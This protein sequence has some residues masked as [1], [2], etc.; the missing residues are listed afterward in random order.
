MLCCKGIRFANLVSRRL[1]L[2]N[3]KHATMPLVKMSRNKKH[4]LA[5]AHA[6]AHTHA[7][8]K[9]PLLLRGGK[10][11]QYQVASRPE[12]SRNIY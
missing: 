2:K 12:A 1:M 5:S 7:R 10:Q 8:A 4:T 11:A 6:H 3:V 9:W